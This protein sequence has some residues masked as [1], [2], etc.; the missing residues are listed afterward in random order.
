MAKYL[1][2][3]LYFEYLLGY[4]IQSIFSFF[5]LVLIMLFLIGEDKI[6]FK[7]IRINLVSMSE[8]V[9]KTFKFFFIKLMINDIFNVK[10]H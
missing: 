9:T 3:V 4:R 2:P 10:N 5:N 8:L 7:A 1:L 6:F